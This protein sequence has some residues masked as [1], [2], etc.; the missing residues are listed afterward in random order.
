MNLRGTVVTVIDLAIRLALPAGSDNGR[1]IIL[2]QGGQS[3]QGVQGAQ[4]G[5]RPVGML[6]DN[7]RD[8]IVVDDA[9][10]EIV[11]DAQSLS[12]L[13]RGIIRIDGGQ[14][15]LLDVRRLMTQVLL[16]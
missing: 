10:V 5:G 1:C 2:I 15:L 11:A 7:V 16:T 6:V 3:G 9:M 13:A 14:V 12:E 8:V 4:G